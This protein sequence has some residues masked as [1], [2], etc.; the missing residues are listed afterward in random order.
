MAIACYH[1]VN[2]VLRKEIWVGSVMA[3]FWS[4]FGGAMRFGQ[5]RIG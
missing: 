2:L 1:G 3:A 5:A 4:A